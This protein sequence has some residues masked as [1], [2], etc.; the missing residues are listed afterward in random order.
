MT[1]K[2]SSII[3]TLFTAICLGSIGC[4]GGD[5]QDGN[6]AAPQK[7]PMPADPDLASTYLQTC[8]SCHGN[9][10]AGAPRTGDVAAWQPRMAKGMDVLVENTINGINGMPPLGMCMDCSEEDFIPLIEFMASGK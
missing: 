6:S 3:T 4:S 9:G 10:Y 2:H 5:N 1:L 8:K 7:A